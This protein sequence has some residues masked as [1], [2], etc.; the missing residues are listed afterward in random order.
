MAKDYYESLGLKKGA[1]A[2]DIK[3][4]Y[5]KMAMK[6]HPDK[7]KGDKASEAKFKEINEAY[8]VLKDDTKRASYDHY[9]H[10][11]FTQGG[12]GGFGGGFGGGGGGFN[13]A[14]GFGGFSDIFENLFKQSQG[15]G[16]GETHHIQNQGSDIR[17]NLE[18][19]LEKAFLGEKTKLRFTTYVACEPCGGSGGEN[20]SKPVTCQTCRGRGQVRFQ[21]GIFT[22]ERTCNACG[23]TGQTIAN[24]CRSCSGQGRVRR[25]KNLEVSIPAGVDD[26]VRIRVNGEGE[27]GV[28]GGPSGDLYIF[29]SLKPHRFFKRSGNDIHVKVPIPMVQAALG[30]EIIV[31]SIDGSEVPVK[32]PAGTQHGQQFRV[33][34]K[35]MS[36]V[37]GNGRGDMIIEAAIEVPVNLSKHQKELLEDFDKDFTKEKNSPQ[38][39]GF[40]SKVKDFWDEISKNAG[41]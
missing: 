18:M 10:S 38:S 22:M 17:Y 26:G 12:A 1:T 27:A 36:V 35:G 41:K 2:A 30:G 3:S 9:G 33:R 11:A 5:R 28:R 37:R 31:P 19:T 8:E 34:L 21:Q 24:P 25:E 4:A 16:G 7:N 15:F 29:I 40:F 20:G 13:G 6:Y 39:H 32:I 14:E 23:G